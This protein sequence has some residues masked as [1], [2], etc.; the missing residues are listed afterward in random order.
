MDPAPHPSDTPRE[1]PEQV[2]RWLSTLVAQR[3]EP[4]RGTAKVI[5]LI[6]GRISRP[7]RRFEPLALARR[8]D[9]PAELWVLVWHLP[10]PSPQR[11]SNTPSKDAKASPSSKA[12]SF[13]IRWNGRAVEQAELQRIPLPKAPRQAL[14]EMG[15]VKPPERVGL[16]R[17]TAPASLAPKEASQGRMHL[18]MLGERPLS[19]PVA[20]SGSDPR[21]RGS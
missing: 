20:P 6:T 16:L 21:E 13:D 4:Q 2:G 18:Q 14:Q 17:L 12:P 5:R 19:I 9:A 10:Q 8:A 3:L 11:L 15:Y 1:A 7:G